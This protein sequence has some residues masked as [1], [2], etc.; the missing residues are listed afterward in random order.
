MRS[1]PLLSL[2][3]EKLLDKAT[4]HAWKACSRHFQSIGKANSNLKMPV[5][6]STLKDYYTKSGHHVVN[7]E[8]SFATLARPSPPKPSPSVPKAKRKKQNPIQEAVSGAVDAM[9][10]NM[11]RKE[12]WRQESSAQ[13]NVL[14][15]KRSRLENLLKMNMKQTW[16]IQTLEPDSA[17]FARM[18]ALLAKETARAE[19]LEAE[20]M[21]MEQDLQSRRKA[22]GTYLPWG[23]NFHL[24]SL[25]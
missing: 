5:S 8:W 15:A 22:F 6:L 4:H 20:V 14:E 17:V 18:Q 21:Q 9:D 12:V 23:P 16:N 2:A 25:L 7:M 10:R 11:T 3:L 19:A 1:D 13:E 24:F